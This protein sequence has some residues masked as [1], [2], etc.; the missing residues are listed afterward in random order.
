[1]SDDADDLPVEAKQ[2]I[3]RGPLSYDPAK[4]RERHVI[5]GSGRSMLTCCFD[6]T[7]RIIVAGGM[8]PDVVQYRF[9][10][11][12]EQVQWDQKGE[13][14]R[15]PAHKS[16]IGTL[17]IAPAGD[18]LFTAGYAGD[19]LAWS[20]PLTAADQ[21]PLWSQPDAHIGWIRSL[22]VS[23]D[24]QTVATCGN[25]QHVRLWSAVDGRLIRQFSGHTCHVYHLAFH[26]TEPRLVSGDLE[27]HIIDWDLST[28]ELVREKHAKQFWVQQANLQLGGVRSMTFHPDGGLLALGGMYGFGSIGDGIGAPCVMFVDWNNFEMLEILTQNEQHRSFVNGI[29]FLSPEVTVAVTGGLDSGMILSW[30]PNEAPAVP[31][32]KPDE[33]RTA[34]AYDH[35]KIAASGWGASV[36]PDGNCI[37]VAHHDQTVRV[38]ELY[39]Q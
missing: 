6:P 26:P 34:K 27:G 2:P 3:V 5:S 23:P 35:H 19:L 39:V 8:L 11:E 18:R 20:F 29:H 24:G 7:G 12:D 16:W 21:S 32:D 37:A 33:I 13:L 25:D 17:G 4:I 38:Y 31:A 1:M 10:V 14:L 28:G 9:A 36:H 30:K 22:A 15:I